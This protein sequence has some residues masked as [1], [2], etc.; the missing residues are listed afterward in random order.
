MSCRSLGDIEL[1]NE[2]DLANGPIISTPEMCT[3]P[4]GSEDMFVVLGSD[5]VWDYLS[6]QEAVD[7]GLAHFGK[8]QAAAQAICQAAFN[9]EA[10]D[11]ITALVVEFSWNGGRAAEFVARV[12]AEKDTIAKKMKNVDMFA[13]SDDD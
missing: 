13:S 5:G 3:H 8:P 6:D 2:D 1:K 9:N 12:Q 10:E 4:I 7:I 11:N